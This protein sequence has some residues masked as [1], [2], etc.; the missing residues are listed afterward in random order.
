VRLIARV[1]G[2]TLIASL[3]T[4]GCGGS[5]AKSDGGGG[6]GGTSSGGRGGGGGAS[7]RGS[8]SATVNRNVDVLFLVD[9]SSSMALAQANLVASFPAFMTYL[10]GLAGGL[11]NLHIAVVSSDMGA[12]TGIAGCTGTGKSGVFQ[13]TPRGSCTTTNLQA[14]ATFISNVDGVANYTGNLEDVF[15][16]IAPL[17]ETGCGFEQQF[18]AI[19]R[20]LGADGKG[21]P[22]AVNAG[23]LRPDAYLAIVMLTNEDDC[24]V[25]EGAS[26]YDA[27]NT[28]LSSPLGPP[29]NFRCNEFGH[30]CDGAPPNRNAPTGSLTDTVTYASCVPAEG[31]GRLK[32]VVQTAQEIKSLKADPASQILV[33]AISGPAGPYQVRWRSPALAD[34][35]PWPEITHSCTAQDTSFADP[36]VRTTAFVQQFDRHGLTLSICDNSLAPALT[37]VAEEI[38]ILLEP[39]CIIGLIASGP[40]GLPD[41][42]VFAHR[43]NASGAMVQ[44]AVPACAASGG[45]SPC[46]QLVPAS[47][48]AGSRLDISIDPAAPPPVGYSYECGVC[49]PNVYEPARGCP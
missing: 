37:R 20:A 22:P 43:I 2:G 19:T 33:T 9:D 32:T 5:P 41:C 14:G 46:W 8:F 45:A 4:I 1:L 12:G 48:C 13:Y 39:P 23:F 38:G 25:A 6:I 44:T 49:T 16:C 24:S 36:S 30:L 47:D 10:R 21:A 35:G 42:N 17:G 29:S 34:T 15:R 18:A 31:S 3:V 11:P 40:T 26:L 7:V 27:T 28:T